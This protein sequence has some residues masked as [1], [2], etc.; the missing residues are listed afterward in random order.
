MTPLLLAARMREPASARLVTLLVARGAD[1]DAADRLGRSPLHLAA[2]AGN[3][4]NT[5]VLLAAGADVGRVDARR[6]ATAAHYAAAFARVDAI[7]LF[8][9]AEPEKVRDAR[10]AHGRS[11]LHWSALSA[12]RDW[13]S[14]GA[15]DVVS[16]LLDAGANARARD[17]N[18]AT[19]AHS[20]ARLGADA[21]LDHLVE[22][23]GA[24]A[25]T[26]DRRPLL[27][28]CDNKGVSPLDI[29]IARYRLSRLKGSFVLDPPEW[30][31]LPRFGFAVSA[32]KFWL[33]E[34]KA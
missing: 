10:D 33:Q 1:T 34:P 30:T 15:R 13:A 29:I 19:P 27:H 8:C 24:D 23:D 12:H 21:F 3:A 6:G 11:P 31:D 5:R 20:A 2:L 16:A 4:A 9:A 7:R 18:G 26:E 22:R 25:A 14:A 32:P 17:K 28:E